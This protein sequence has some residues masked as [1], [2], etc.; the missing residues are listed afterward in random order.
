M[1]RYDRGVRIMI[2]SWE[3]VVDYLLQNMQKQVYKKDEKLPSEHE[4]AQRF[5]LTRIEI[6]KAYDR[7]KELGYV[8]SKQGKGNYYAGYLEKVE[9]SLSS[10][11]SFSNKMSTMSDRFYTRVISCDKISYQREIYAQLQAKEDETVLCIKRLRYID[12]MP[13]A[14]HI[15]YVKQQ[16]FPTIKEALGQNPSLYAFFHKEGMEGL[17][18]EDVS[19]MVS[20][21]NTEERVYM[22]VSGIVPCLLVKSRTRNANNEILEVSTIIYRG[23]KFIFKM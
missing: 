19:L 23:D 2:T 15:S 12:Q 13:S 8:Y 9:L 20:N 16:R 7:L 6:R 4:L 22:N 14:M 11:D 10:C 3:P 17:K 18:T 1:I 21:L 5:Q